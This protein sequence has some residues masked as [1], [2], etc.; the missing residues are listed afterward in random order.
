MGELD[1]QRV[2][3][4]GGG[5]GG[6]GNGKWRMGN[7]DGGM[8]KGQYKNAGWSRRREGGERGEGRG[9]VE[10][11]WSGDVGC[12]PIFI[13]DSMKRMVDGTGP[14]SRFWRSHLSGYLMSHKKKRKSGKKKISL[15]KIGDIDKMRCNE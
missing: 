2:I 11:G 12:G 15:G 5:R 14:E 1:L 9:G 3:K 10:E 8:R 4:Q 13:S 7:A 6:M